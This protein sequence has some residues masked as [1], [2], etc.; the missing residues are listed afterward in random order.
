VNVGGSLGTF[1]IPPGASVVDNTT[2]S[3][4]VGIAFTGVTAAETTTFYTAALPSAGYTITQNQQ[5][6]G[7]SYTGT[8]IKFTGH[9]YD[10]SIGALSGTGILGG[11]SINGTTGAVVGVTLTPQS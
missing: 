7:D 10:G 11:L 3:G 6:T 5:V 8:G 2:S 4:Q 1:P 9:G